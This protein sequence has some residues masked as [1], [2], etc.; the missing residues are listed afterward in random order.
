MKKAQ[1][2]ESSS[3]GRGTSEEVV[4]RRPANWNNLHQ[5]LKDKEKRERER[6]ER[7]RE[8]F[9]EA[10]CY[11]IL[12][13]LQFLSDCFCMFVSCF[14]WHPG[15]TAAIVFV[16]NFTEQ[17]PTY[18]PHDLGLSPYIYIYIY[19][20]SSTRNKQFAHSLHLEQKKCLLAPD[21]PDHLGLSDDI[22]LGWAY[23]QVSEMSH[24]ET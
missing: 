17:G 3:S 11:L 16:G 1:R 8:K 2:G 22:G 20:Y 15:R 12:L 19:I 14:V 21:S 23:G 5:E 10:G 6:R 13:Y 9:L 18:I 7:E 4:L 24:L